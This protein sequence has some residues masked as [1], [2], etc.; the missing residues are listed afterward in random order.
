[1]SYKSG[2]AAMNLEFT[3]RVPRTEYSADFHWEL[4]SAVTGIAVNNNSGSDVKYKAS[5]CFKEIWNYG[6]VWNVLVH[7]QYL[8]GPKSSMGHAVYQADGSD[9]RSDVYE[10][11]KTPEEIYK[12]D[13]FDLYGKIDHN[14]MVNEFNA[15]Y[16]A[17][18]DSFSD[19]VNMTGIYITCI[20][21]LIEMLGWE[22]LLEALGE[23]AVKFGEFTKRYC[24]WISQHFRALA[25]CDAD[26]VMIHDDIVWT[27]GA[28]VAPA[29]YREYVFPNYKKMFAPLVEA[30]KKILYTSDGTYTEFLDDIAACG[31]N[32]FVFEPTTDMQYAADKYG[33]THV[34]VGNAD[35]RILLSGTKDDIYNEVKRCMDIGKQYPGFIMAVGNHI[36]PNTPVENCMWYNECYEKLGKR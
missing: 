13:M 9:Y 21:G 7:S 20:S 10:A 34:L 19:T 1:M 28:F 18:C 26:V 3:D 29:W 15:H 36:P 12:L 22:M 8:T 4:I 16:K 33:K 35:T 25:D 23:D 2:M 17:S 27:E 5:N 11:F 6:M 14:K 30:G 31:V 32:G 24:D